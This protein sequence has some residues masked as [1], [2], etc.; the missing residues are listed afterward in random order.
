MEEETVGQLIR[1]LRL[2]KGWERGDL[3]RESGVDRSLISRFETGKTR[4]MRTPN[5]RALTKALDIEDQFYELDRRQLATPARRTR[6]KK[7]PPEQIAS[8][9]KAVSD[10]LL[11][12]VEKIDRRLE[13][14]ELQMKQLLVEDKEQWAVVRERQPGEPIPQFGKRKTTEE[15]TEE[16]LARLREQRSKALKTK[17]R[18][19][20]RKSLS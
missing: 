12:V 16:T 20:T 4:Q 15:L 1:R 18:T 2:A 10:Q 14:M 5:L 13:R 6:E 17:K 3:E 8:G 19:G 7:Q 9:L 11:A